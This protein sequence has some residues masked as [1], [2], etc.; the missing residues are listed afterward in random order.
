MEVRVEVDVTE[1]K[2][3]LAGLVSPRLERAASLALNDTAKAAQVQAVKLVAPLLELPSREI[4]QS[5]G[6]GPPA[7]P[8]GR[9]EASVVGSGRP[10]KL[11]RF[12]AR[13][14]HGSG[15]VVR[16]GR[17]QETLRRAF[18]ATMRTGHVGVFDR[19]GAARHPI[20]ELY[21]PSVAG[22]FAR[23]DVLD[24][25]TQ[26]MGRELPRKLARQVDRQLRS[27]RGLA[28]PTRGGE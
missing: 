22:M 23:R 16:I 4:K 14:T 5:I 8:S 7:S 26:T 12:K 19:Q 13:D 18:I 6:L 11:I 17:R 9:L 21:G 24:V 10:I 25:V 27:A 1:L 2:A 3:V 28:R 20:R 15:V